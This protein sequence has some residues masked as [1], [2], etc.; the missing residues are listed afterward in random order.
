[1]K[2][3]N[4]NYNRYIAIIIIIV[5]LVG[6]MPTFTD[7]SAKPDDTGGE[8]QSEDAER[9]GQSD[10]AD[11]KT[12]IKSIIP[13]VDKKEGGIE[14]TVAIES[15][16]DMRLFPKTSL[17]IKVYISAEDSQK[18]AGERIYIFKLKPYE[19]TT[20]ILNK[21]E[22]SYEAYFDVNQ[23]SS[24]YSHDVTLL[25]SDL[26]NLNSGEIYNKFVAAVKEKD[27]FKAITDAKYIDNIN[28]LSNKKETPPVSKTK[29][30]LIIQML[31]E[32]RILGVGYTTIDMFLNDF[33]AAEGS[34]NT[35]LYVYGDENYYFNIDKISEYDK[36][37][38][39][40]TNEGINVAARLLIN[41]G[42]IPSDQS[43]NQDSNGENSE[44]NA[45]SQLLI[46]VDP[47]QYLIHPNALASVQSDP[48]K[49]FYYYGINTTN[50]KGV[51]YFEA[52]MSF[53]ADRYVKDDKGY[54]RIYNI[55][56][57][58]TIG[59]A[60]LFNYCGKKD[61]IISYV[62]NYLRALRICD[63]AMRSRFGGSR[64]YVQLSNLFAVS[65]GRDGDFANKDLI[66]QLCEYSQ[67][68]GNFIWNIA[69]NAYNADSLNPEF[70]K[71]TAPTG[72]FSTPI[73]TMKNIEVLCNYLNL[74]MKDFLPNGEIRKVMLSDQG[75]SS[76]DNSKENME[77]QAA[78][79]AYAYLKA[80]YIPDITSFIYHGHVDQTE[81][82][83]LGLWTRIPD[84]AN[85]PGEKKKIYD[86]FKY[87]DTNREA[88]KTEFIKSVLGPEYAAEIEKLQSKDTEPAIMLTEATGETL[89]S[90]PNATNIGSFNDDRL[91]GFIGSSNISKMSRVIYSNKD[92][93]D[94]HNKSML[95]AGFSNTVKGDF[96]GISKIY[97]PEEPALN[98][99]G[100]KYVGVKLRIDTLMQMPED[101]KIQLILI[102]ESEPV[103]Q[104]SGTGNDTAGT[105]SGTGQNS[106]NT[107]T[108]KTLSIFEGLAN[109]SP[110]KDETVYFD[111]STWEDKTDI[112]KIKLLVNP[113]ANP[114]SQNLSPQADSSG[115]DTANADTAGKY[116]FNL[117]VYSI[118]SAHISRT[119]VFKTLLI[120]VLVI[121]FIVVAGYAALYIRAQMIKKKRREMRAYQKRRAQLAA[122][123]KQGSP[124]QYGN[125]RNLN[126]AQNNQHRRGT[127]KP[128]DNRNDWNDNDKRR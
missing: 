51:K 54:G 4:K 114:A 115:N 63:T 9:S 119:S 42:F 59:E 14:Q 74:E 103:S 21:D 67:K 23:N 101:Q 60:S 88:E 2:S 111:I 95:F 121:I 72:E 110:N 124:G 22:S 58:S 52:L 89:K 62:K 17:K 106:N 113:Y 11:E 98:L 15:R 92:S 40:L 81:V 48:N 7:V 28:Y 97:T 55:I 77:L 65:S 37:I 75:Y 112:K 68:E 84:T 26:S 85:D 66:R 32:A 30:G 41:K 128:K 117:Y 109:I 1:M 5:V 19:E 8:S 46:P 78:A 96:A 127:A 50:E 29:K 49:A 31:G 20:D 123:R 16:E 79:F 6:I 44:D 36:K 118:V 104:S 108:V 53:I 34:A 90:R 43:G 64:V 13:Y 69:V 102:I 25:T 47:I 125:N 91:S 39:Y 38:K 35:E 82:G 45:I 70:W 87:M 27:Q 61:D 100:E 73:I 122:S 94:F 24:G 57:G 105:A 10:Q 83:S 80:K 107:N 116:D 18:Y 3:L 56:L 99:T 120:I 33:M 12:R 71:E 126:Q 93:E 86:V 76:G